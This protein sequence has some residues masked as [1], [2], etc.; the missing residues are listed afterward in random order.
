MRKQ[1][2]QALAIAY[3]VFLAAV[4]WRAEVKYGLDGATWAGVVGVTFLVVLWR[5]WRGLAY[6]FAGG[7]VPTS[8]MG[9]TQFQRSTATKARH[10]P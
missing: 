5:L 6:I 2:L 8:V 10:R 7:R 9:T 3:L 4:I 1:I